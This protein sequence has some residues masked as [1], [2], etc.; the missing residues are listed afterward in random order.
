MEV[1]GVGISALR[2]GEL[3]CDECWRYLEWSGTRPAKGFC[4]VGAKR[5]DG[6]KRE[7]SLSRTLAWVL[8]IACAAS[9]RGNVPG[10]SGLLGLKSKSQQAAVLT[11]SKVPACT[12]TC[13]RPPETEASAVLAA[14]STAV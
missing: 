12:R 6:A 7:F 8:W 9:G 13:P 5:G 4:K 1:P 14:L 3:S 10:L 2:C 11:A